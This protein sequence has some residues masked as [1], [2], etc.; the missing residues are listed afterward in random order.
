MKNETK[1]I[2]KNNVQIDW[3]ANK[4]IRE[5]NILTVIFLFGKFKVGFFLCNWFGRFNNIGFLLASY[6][7]EKGLVS[8]QEK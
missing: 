3:S 5:N 6:E 8:C 4:F 7:N 2:C 1:L